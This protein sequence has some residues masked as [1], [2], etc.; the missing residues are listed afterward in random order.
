M[1]GVRGLCRAS[2]LPLALGIPGAIEDAAAQSVQRDLLPQTFLERQPP[3]AA[4]AA[5]KEARRRAAEESRRLADELAREGKR[6]APSSS[7]SPGD[8]KAASA[9]AITEPKPVTDQPADMPAALSPAVPPAPAAPRDTTATI[10]VPPPVPAA[11]PAITQPQNTPQ[12]TLSAAELEKL[13]R[14][15]EARIKEGDIASAR[16]VYQRAAEGGSVTASRIL[17]RLFDGDALAQL[18]AR[19]VAADAEK[20]RFWLAHADRLERGEGRGNAAR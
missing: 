12:V 18:G 2:M 10:V 5:Q 6:D 4:D 7:P 3:P 9:V 14:L 13:I 17:A 15:G 16:L 1:F 8:A 19:G 11:R 20:S